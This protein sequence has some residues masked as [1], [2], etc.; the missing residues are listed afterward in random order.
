MST[1]ASVTIAP[2]DT[3]LLFSMA[4]PKA[5]TA[6]FADG[7][8]VELFEFYSDELTFRADEFVGLTAEQARRLHRERDI[9]YLRS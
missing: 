1:I 5:V 9:A 3:A 8:T 2:G 7:S 4:E 6:T